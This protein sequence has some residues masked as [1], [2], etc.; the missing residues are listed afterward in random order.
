MRFTGGQGYELLLAPDSASLSIGAEYLAFAEVLQRFRSLLAVLSREGVPRCDRIGVRYLSVATPSTPDS[1]E[2]VRWFKPE[3]IGWTGSGLLSPTTSL[4]SALNQVTLV[5]SPTQQL[6]QF[7][8]D[9]QAII[10]HGLVPA[11]SAIHG[12][13]PVKIARRSYLIE[14]D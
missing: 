9:V 6:A 14:L 13:P 8:G 11:G 3:F 2:W 10:R 5:S 4:F 1:D 7:P 12:V